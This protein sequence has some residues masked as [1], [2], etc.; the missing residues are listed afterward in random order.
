MNIL[1][2]GGDRWFNIGIQPRKYVSENL[3]VAEMTFNCHRGYCLIAKQYPIQEPSKYLEE[4]NTV[5]D[6]ICNSGK[7]IMATFVEI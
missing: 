4:S 6:T 5:F 2:I 7:Y 1:Y 3:I